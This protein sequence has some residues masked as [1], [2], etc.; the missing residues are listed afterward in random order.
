MRHEI[1]SLFSD[2]P[3]AKP[4]FTIFA[5]LNFTIFYFGLGFK[6]AAR[7]TAHAIHQNGHKQPFHREYLFFV[8]LLTG[9]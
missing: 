6:S 4:F 1:P 7:K 2:F 3:G 5:F 9:P 8:F